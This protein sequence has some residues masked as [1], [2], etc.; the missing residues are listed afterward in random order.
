M[1]TI[2]YFGNDWNAENRTSTHHIARRLA[3]QHQVYYIECPG[4]RAPRRSGRD[5]RRVFQKVGRSLRG[6][7]EVL[8]GLKVQTL[9]QIP[10]HR[11]AVTRWLNAHLVLWSIRWL[12]W[13]HGIRRPILW[14][15]APHVASLIGRLG[16]SLSVYYVTDDHA[17]MPGIDRD[18]MR[19]MDEKLT[20]EAGIVFVASD[21]LLDRKLALNPNTHYSP[22]GV[23][24]E[25]FGRACNPSGRVPDDIRPFPQPIIGFFGLVERWIDLGLVRYLAEERPDWTFLMI[26]RIGVPPETVPSL[27]N[28]HFVGKRTYEELPDY[29]RQ[30]AAAILPFTLTQEAWHAN[31]LKLLEYLAMGKPVVSVAIPAAEKLSDVIEVAHN[32]EEFLAR[33]DKAVRES[34]DAEAVL[35]RIARAAAAS[36]DA[37]VAE[38]LRLVRETL[39]RNR[40]QL[41][42][43]PDEVAAIQAAQTTRS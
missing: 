11:F 4:M 34:K 38:V 15:V 19:A 25:H 2:L 32:R 28:L 12:M 14:F 10:L 23:D 16:E 26:G 8:P 40:S 27:P 42:A 43:I 6:A 13:R 22:H 33:L 7:R 21:T 30:F 5:L 31:P 35:R 17:S 20:R 29:G 3:E 24:V 36:W 39:E 18:S 41:G 9:L 37:R 1:A